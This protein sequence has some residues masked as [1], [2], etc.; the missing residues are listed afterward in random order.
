[1]FK[2]DRLCSNEEDMNLE[3]NEREEHRWKDESIE[4]VRK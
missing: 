3:E 1:M 4:D 2:Q